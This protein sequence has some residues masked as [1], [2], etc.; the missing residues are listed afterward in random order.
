MAYADRIWRAGGDAELHVFAGAFHG[1]DLFA[2]HTAVGRRMIHVR[3]SW[4][5]KI[6]AD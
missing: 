5:E 1:C 6:L 2:P 4:V 3:N